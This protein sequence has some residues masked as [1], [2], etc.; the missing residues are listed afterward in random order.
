MNLYIYLSYCMSK[1]RYSIVNIDDYYHINIESQTFCRSLFSCASKTNIKYIWRKCVHV[2]EAVRGAHE[3]IGATTTG[4]IYVPT[5]G[6]HTSHRQNLKIESEK[7]TDRTKMDMRNRLCGK[8]DV[9]QRNE[10][11]LNDVSVRA[12]AHQVPTA[13]AAQE[14]GIVAV[15]VQAV[16]LHVVGVEIAA[17]VEVQ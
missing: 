7:K 2:V 10:S 8:S 3:E 12:P 17:V 16:P 5:G 1:Y 15:A 11:L 9:V 14:A 4:P 6:K 13:A